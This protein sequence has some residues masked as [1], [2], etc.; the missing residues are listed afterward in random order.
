MEQIVAE[1]TSEL[2]QVAAEIKLTDQQTCLV[3]KAEAQEYIK[4]RQDKKKGSLPE[5]ELSEQKHRVMTGL[6]GQFKKVQ[7]ATWGRERDGLVNSLI[8]TRV[9]LAK[10]K[11][12]LEAAKALK[13]KADHQVAEDAIGKIR[14]AWRTAAESAFASTDKKSTAAVKYDGGVMCRWVQPSAG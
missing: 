6:N 7:L 11:Y 10:M 3:T 8:D 1:A 13:L 12:A 4:L 5:C 9:A 2:D 14:K